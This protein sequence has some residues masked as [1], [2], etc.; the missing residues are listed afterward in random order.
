MIGGTSG[1]HFASASSSRSAIRSGS[2]QSCQNVAPWV[3]ISSSST[4][5]NHK[6]RGPM[7]REGGGRLS[8]TTQQ[9]TL[10][11]E[12]CQGVV[13]PLVWRFAPDVF[14]HL[15]QDVVIEFSIHRMSWWN[16]FLMHNTFSFNLLPHFRSWFRS[17]VVKNALHNRLTP[18]RSGNA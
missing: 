6:G 9:A 13:A 14:P 4:G 12:C 1:S 17:K 8:Y 18:I 7:S 10:D 5:E 15:P 16:K 3:S 11:P 2:L